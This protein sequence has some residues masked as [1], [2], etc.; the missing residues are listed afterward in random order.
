MSLHDCGI[1]TGLT[2]RECRAAA[3]WAVG[4]RVAARTRLALRASTC[5]QPSQT[6]SAENA[7]ASRGLRGPVDGSSHARAGNVI[8]R[9]RTSRCKSVLPP[10]PVPRP[11]KH[12]APDRVPALS[13]PIPPNRALAL[14]SQPQRHEAPARA[15]PA[16]GHALPLSCWEPV[17]PRM[18]PSA[19]CVLGSTA[20]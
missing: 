4:C 1:L 18:P 10:A 20:C 14:P 19:V 8:H 16:A 17:E 5:S 2:R 11:C 6:G 3:S 13:L 7:P 9:Q 15:T 12:R